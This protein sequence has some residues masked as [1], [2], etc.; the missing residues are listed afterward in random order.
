MP[1]PG[2]DRDAAAQAVEYFLRYGSKR[3]AAKALGV[4]ESSF[5][6]RLRAA[7]KLG[8]MGTKP[9][10][11]GYYLHRTSTQLGPNGELQREWIQ[12]KQEPGEEFTVPDGHVVKGVSALLDADGRTL[13][14]WVKTREDEAHREIT[15]RAFIDGCKDEMPRELPVTAPAF[16]MAELLSQY[17][18]TDMHLGALSW[19]EETGRGDYDLSIGE[20]LFVDWFGAAIASA[21]A[22][23]V[24]VLAQL[25]DFLHYDSFKSVTPEHGHQLDAD[26]RYPKMVRTAIR[27]MRKV[28]RML[29]AKHEFVH[30]KMS[31]ANHD[32]AGEVWLRELFAVLYEDEPRVTVD[33]S[34]GTYLVY[35]HGEVVLFYHH[36]HRRKLSDVDTMFVARFREIYGRTRFAYGHTGHKHADELLTT[37]LMKVEQHETL[38]AP[39]AFGSNWI[40]GRSAKV[41]NYHARR[42]EVGRVILTPEM[43][44]DFAA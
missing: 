2:F 43:V 18:V 33:T 9:V 17:T 15:L 41:I 34:P 23:K 32:P 35:E 12:Q 24:A 22:S 5:Y 25:G 21:P 28:I 20:K 7:A 38:A 11:P 14:Q 27:A 13:Q 40:A 29:L 16:V 4:D 37:D 42:G 36:G 6:R 30:I 3:E 19:N 39:D 31:D 1:N 44:A 10:L 26:S 8:I